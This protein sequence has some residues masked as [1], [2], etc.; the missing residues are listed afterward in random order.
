MDCALSYIE[1]KQKHNFTINENIYN[2]LFLNYCKFYLLKN[3]SDEYTEEFNK[4]K[5]LCITYDNE[6]K[7]ET[8]NILKSLNIKK[9]NLMSLTEII[10]NMM[11]LPKDGIKIEN[12]TNKY[13]ISH[14]NK[15]KISGYIIDNWSYKYFHYNGKN[16][17][18]IFK[19]QANFIAINIKNYF[20]IDKECLTDKIIYLIVDDL[21]CEIKHCNETINKLYEYYENLQID[22]K[23]YTQLINNNNVELV[24]RIKKQKTRLNVFEKNINEI[25][26][27]LTNNINMV[28]K[29][30]IDYIQ[31]VEKKFID[32]TK[33]INDSFIK[34]KNENEITNNNDKLLV[35]EI[36]K[37][38]A[39]FKKENVSELKKSI[40]EILLKNEKMKN[41]FDEIIITNIKNIYTHI[42]ELHNED[43]LNTKIKNV[44]LELIE[45]IENLKLEIINERKKYNIIYF[46]IFIIGVFCI[47][48]QELLNIY[49]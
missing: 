14:F 29:G 6:L 44:K 17:K 20:K 5:E 13:I 40:N 11:V 46:I 41:D 43:T 49:H 35:N 22:L 27:I 42:S 31:V 38:H 23:N 36:K 28:E 19:E 9:I 48:N 1:Y 32:E 16:I 18:E 7:Y 3:M 10:H 15:L 2:D 47:M 8:I 37:I 26:E 24:S 30:Y 4:C 12:I 21:T 39:D 45:E 34:I 25:I 33:K